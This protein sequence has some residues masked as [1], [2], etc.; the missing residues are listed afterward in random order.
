MHNG[1]TAT[2]GYTGLR[3]ALLDRSPL[4]SS[5]VMIP[6]VEI[7]ELLAAA[8]FEAVVVDLEHGAVTL[9][10]LPPLAAAARGAGIFCIARLASARESEISSA[11]DAGVD[12]VIIPH[13]DSADAARLVVSAGRFPP[14]GDRSL[15]PYTR[16][17]G[18]G[19]GNGRGRENANR[20]V[21]VIVMLEGEGAVA[22][23]DEI[24]AVSGIDAV[25]V[26]PV[27]LSSALGVPGEPEHPLVIAEITR[28]FER[29]ADGAIAGGIYAPTP[30]A[31]DRWLEAGASLIT[32]SADIAMAIRSFAETR[33][34]ISQAPSPSA[35]ADH[36]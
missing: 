32:V 19:W 7:V 25:F 9:P 31:A 30:E 33:S 14:E 3:K 17:T 34:Q 13:V 8:G 23:L 2:D 29:L 4:V 15:N 6:R 26:G 21:A 20:R 22:A 18:Y 35:T 24:S 12:G 11:L 10:D 36:D 1:T 27:D 28:I 5:F 16:G